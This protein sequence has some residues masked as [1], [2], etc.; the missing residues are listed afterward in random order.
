MATITTNTY[1]DEGTA[2]TAGEAWTCNGGILTVRTDTRWHAD[3][4]ASMTG[5]LGSVNISATLGG[6]YY[7]DGTAVRWLAIT[8]GS[9]TATI[10]DTIS[11]GAV[12]GYFLGFWSSLTATPS[13]TIGAT[14]FI[15]LREV[16]GGTFSAGALTFSGSGAATAAGA[17]VAGW[18]EVVQ[19]QAT[20]ITVPRLGKFQVRGDW[21]YLDETTGSANQLIQVPTNGSATTYVPGV[22][23][24][25]SAGSGAYEY[26]PSIY[27]AGMSTTN[28]GTD[29]RSKFVCME[30][31][32]RVRIGHNGTT[33]VGFVPSSGCKV[34]IP[35]VLGRQCATGTRA[36]NAIPHATAG[37][38]PDFATTSAGAVD[39]EYFA[40]DWYLSFAQPYSVRIQHSATFDYVLISECASAVD[41]YDGGNSISQSI[42]QRT[43][44]LTSCFAGGT[45]TDWTCYRYAAGSNDHACEN[46]Y[47]IGQIY[48]RVKSGIVTFARSSGMSFQTTQS[49]NITYNDCYARN[50][51]FQLT[52]SFN[53]T[54]DGL[55][56]CDRFVGTTNTTGIYA[57]YILASCS[58][59]SVRN[60]TF[61]LKGTISNVHPYLGIFNIG[62]STNIK[63]RECG[64]RSSYLSG[65][66]A[67][68][69]AYIF[70]SAGN[71]VNVKV[72]RVYMTPTRTGAISTQNSDKGNL[73]EHVYG[74][75]GDTMVLASLN[76]QVK[77]CGGTNTT[78]G[79]ASVY[80][81]HFW[82]AFTSDT[83]GR[84][85]CSMNEATAE[86]ASYV[87]TVSLATGSGFTSAGNL[88][89]ATA[90]D[91]VIVEQS[92][93]VLGCTELPNTAPV[94]TGTNVTYSSGPNW[95]NHE[96]Y[97]Q[98]D[99]NDGNGW[100]GSWKDLTGDNLAG[101]TVSPSLGFKLKYRIV[102]GVGV[103]TNLLTYI[104]IATTSTLAA[105][106]DNLYPL[107]LAEVTINNPIVGSSYEIYNITNSTQLAVGT[108]A[109]DPQT[110]SVLASSGNTLRVRLRR[111]KGILLF[112]SQTA[113]FGVGNILAGETSGATAIIGAMTD[114]GTTGSL[115][116]E[117]IVGVF[118]DGEIITDDGGGSATANGSVGGKYLPFEANAV[119]N[120][121]LEASVYANQVVDTIAV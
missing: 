55:D 12:S 71:N 111:S 114:S 22:W 76:S 37:T 29:E 88:S 38:R 108:I 7:I 25:T 104:R 115:T 53:C 105:Q 79:Q 67:N 35:N 96:L 74:D 91:E 18:I 99:V 64:S 9:G 17:D 14:G 84:V 100:N 32:G 106:T 65:G 2:R 90:G 77:N 82:D 109:T 5:S 40:T 30:T 110:V 87:T 66:S 63:L 3:A 4:P 33:T 120:A 19:D 43:L 92:Y 41:L 20:A 1:L 31:D 42:D 11:Q 16:T 117:N 28:L 59:I 86:S 80:G 119:V 6:G 36:T 52:T 72:Q 62:Q 60:V 78:T 107:D 58:D 113:D 61:G 15:K 44:Q 46:I 112:E 103:S 49:T 56:H 13:A 51:G 70:V 34:R 85:V 101:E 69:P 39:I 95:G 73:Y 57:V 8:G 45:I 102:C 26:Y 24:E 97:Y 47:S 81:T 93:F 50:H 75:M 68:N 89:L 48:T 23:I 94:V 21:F 10:G 98:I 116:L 27:A 83:A 54:V 118:L 121:S